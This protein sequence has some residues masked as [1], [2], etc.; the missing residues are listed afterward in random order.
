[1]LVGGLGDGLGMRVKLQRDD[2]VYIL[3]VCI[4]GVSFKWCYVLVWVCVDIDNQCL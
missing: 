4:G 1:M 3:L 2:S